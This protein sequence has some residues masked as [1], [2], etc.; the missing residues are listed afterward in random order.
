MFFKK[1]NGNDKYHF[2][3]YRAAR[4]HPFIVVAVTEEKDE[5]GKIFLSGYMMT[6]SI[7]RAMEKPGTYK[8]LKVNPN[9]NDD[10]I[11]FVNKYRVSD[12]PA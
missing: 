9:P 11:S 2:R 3:F 5:G 1:Y 7:Q 6:T 10:K 12:I 8:R 4:Y